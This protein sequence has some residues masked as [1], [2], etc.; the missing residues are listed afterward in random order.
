MIVTVEVVVVVTTS[1][2]KAVET[3]KAQA[4]LSAVLFILMYLFFYS[5][6]AYGEALL[7]PELRVENRKP[8]SPADSTWTRLLAV[9]RSP[10]NAQFERAQH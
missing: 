9:T 8:G 1:A 5:A 2:A 6:E 7:E 10:R 4:R 3:T